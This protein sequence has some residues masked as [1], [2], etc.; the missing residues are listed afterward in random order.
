M[1]HL[2][3][4]PRRTTDT[5]EESEGEVGSDVR[6]ATGAAGEVMRRGLFAWADRRIHPAAVHTWLQRRV[7]RSQRLGI[8]RLAQTPLEPIYELPAEKRRQTLQALVI[9]HKCSLLC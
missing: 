5:E 9:R 7:S 8:A 4:F 1:D 6:D 3:R 2:V